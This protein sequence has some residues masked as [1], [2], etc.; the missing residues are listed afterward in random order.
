MRLIR[1]TG[2]LLE[3]LL[4][5]T[6]PLWGDGLT[7]KGYG[8]WNIAQERTEWGTSHL[9]R[10]ALMDGERVLSSAKR[11]DLSLW[12]KG[13]RVSGL[14]VGAVFT[15]ESQRGHG[16]AAAIVEAL[17]DQAR[18]DGAE[19]SLLFSEIGPSYYARLGYT[20][21][22]L[23]TVE[24]EVDQKDGA[25]AMMVRA[26]ENSD[27]AGVAAMHDQRARGFDLAM[28]PDEAQ[29]RYSISKKR[30]FAGLGTGLGR[31]IE[32]FVSEEGH[33]AVAFLLIQVTRGA[34]GQS[35]TWSIEACGDRDPSGA[36]LGAMLQVLLARAPSAQRPIIRAWWPD[37]LRPPQLRIV[38]RQP[39]GEVMMLKPLGTGV[40]L[41]AVAAEG[42]MYWHGDVF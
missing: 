27:A 15:P 18:G 19:V 10:F 35:D 30:M 39:A 29:V 28:L 17:E 41:D 2:A 37:S 6:F 16:H 7:R 34:S 38:P 20:Q 5:D 31:S 13:R 14:G 9:R 23:Q 26:G 3:S 42:V 22:P 4:D 33:Q 32:Y 36:R 1:A 21:I 11:Y 8:Q 24:V 12:L 25:P 40:A